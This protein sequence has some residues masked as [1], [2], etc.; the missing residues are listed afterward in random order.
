MKLRAKV[1]KGQLWK[2]LTNGKIVK[3]TGK[4]T[5]NRHWNVNQIDGAKQ[6]HHIHEGTLTKFY[7]L[8]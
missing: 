4:A 6:T 1:Q 3:V 5:G 2:S 8:Q 7:R